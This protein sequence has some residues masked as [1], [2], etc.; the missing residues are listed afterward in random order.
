[1][2]VI[3]NQIKC[4]YTDDI[5]AVKDKTKHQY[6]KHEHGA[7]PSRAG[8]QH[9]SWSTLCLHCVHT[10]PWLSEHSMIGRYLVARPLPALSSVCWEIAAV[11]F[12]FI[13]L[14]ITPYCQ[15]AACLPLISRPFIWPLLVNLISWAS[16]PLC[17]GPPSTL[18][19]FRPS[20]C[21]L[22]LENVWFKC[23]CVCLPLGG[24]L[25][26]SG[27]GSQRPSHMTGGCFLWK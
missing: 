6:G 11:L 20:L 8:N 23:C 19:P 1:M 15:S 25:P 17:P 10:D 24:R 12:S 27:P 21:S 3:F 9:T 18:L 4:C 2:Q 5:L 7:S 22:N 13:W 16:P 14:L 26:P